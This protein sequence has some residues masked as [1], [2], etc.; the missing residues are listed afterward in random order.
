MCINLS[1]RDHQ[2][3]TFVCAG[4]ETKEIARMLGKSESA[5]FK[6]IN[7]LMDLYNAKNRSHLSAKYLRER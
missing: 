4:L 3:M 7:R 2:V 6:H 1:A 5:V